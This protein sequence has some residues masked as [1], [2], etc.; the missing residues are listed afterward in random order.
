MWQALEPEL[1]KLIS[2]NQQEARE[3]KL[4]WQK[5]MADLRA[6]LQRENEQRLADAQKVRVRVCV[7][8][9]WCEGGGVHAR[10]RHMSV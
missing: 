10:A 1:H 2:G 4:Q 7:C 3:R 6:E 9:G 5:K 8:V